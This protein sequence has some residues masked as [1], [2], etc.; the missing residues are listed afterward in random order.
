[1]HVELN[2]FGL[3]LVFEMIISQ[4]VVNLID[5]WWCGGAVCGK[6]GGLEEI[7]IQHFRSRDL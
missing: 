2:S 4:K 3:F 5:D 7:R 6:T 1:M